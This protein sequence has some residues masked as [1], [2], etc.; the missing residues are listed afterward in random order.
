MYVTKPFD[1]GELRARVGVGARVVELQKGLATRVQEL[2]E[3][4]TRVKQLQGLL[5]ICS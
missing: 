4:L 3:A 1:A 5:P 2:E